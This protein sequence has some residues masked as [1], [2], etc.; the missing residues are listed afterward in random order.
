MVQEFYPGGGHNIEYHEEYRELVIYNED[1]DVVEMLQIE[2]ES[3]DYE[4]LLK[5]VLNVAIFDKEEIEYD[6]ETESNDYLN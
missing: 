6:I 3:I 1:L 4:V 2:N 5:W